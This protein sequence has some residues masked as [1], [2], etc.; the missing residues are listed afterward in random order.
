[1]RW[2]KLSTKFQ[3]E[4]LQ[5]ALTV[6][7]QKALPVA[8]QQVGIAPGL[9]QPYLPNLLPV[10]AS[11]IASSMST[12][13]SAQGIS[14]FVLETSAIGQ[15]L[16]GTKPDAIEHGIK[17]II[18]QPGGSLPTSQSSV[19]LNSNRPVGAGVLDTPP[20]TSVPTTNNDA[21][22]LDVN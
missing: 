7:I 14:L 1:M 8:L 21:P 10:L 9:I 5:K 19:P 2:G 17:P 22:S 18:R 11:T 16:L 20:S 4:L 13:F 15:H 3:E 6:E 12:N